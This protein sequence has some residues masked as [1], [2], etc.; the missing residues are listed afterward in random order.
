MRS[1]AQGFDVADPALV[2]VKALY[3]EWSA[4]EQQNYRVTGGYKMMIDHLATICKQNKCEI[5]TGK[6]VEKVEWQTGKV[7]VF[8]GNTIYEGEKTFSNHSC[9]VTETTG[10][11]H[12]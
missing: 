12:Y 7:K 5:I 1:F 4:E 6:P 3:E 10:R 2:S 8:T 9:G 11:I